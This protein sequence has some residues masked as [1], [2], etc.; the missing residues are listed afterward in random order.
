[1]KPLVITSNMF[2]ERPRLERWFN[3]VEKVADAGIIIVDTGSTDG[4]IEYARERGA[5]VIVDD[6]IRREGY[7]PARNHLRE[8][9]RQHFPS[10]HWCCYFDADEDLNEAEFHTLRWIKDYL[11]P[12]YDVVAFPRIDWHD[13]EKTKAENDYRYAPD[14]QARMTRLYSP[15]KYV[16]RLHE[17]ITQYK[18]IY[19]NLTTPKLNHYHRA[20]KEVRE[21]IGKLCAAL[22]NADKEFGH[23]YPAHKKEK[24]YY[25]LFLKEG[26]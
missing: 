22:H 20:V 24:H 2:N 3:W 19:V 11:I 15:I 23:T 7:G 17:Q 10:A 1:M 12:E 4:T 21:G 8:M 16:R 13:W 26:L 18:G 14:W 25:D 5:K 6:I 9:A